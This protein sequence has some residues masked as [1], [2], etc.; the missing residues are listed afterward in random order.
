MPRYGGKNVYIDDSVFQRK[1]K[2]LA[3]QFGVDQKEFIKDQTGLLAREAARFTPPWAGFP[4]FTGNSVGT[5]KDIKAGE[6]A[7]YND[8][9]KICAVISDDAAERARKYSK[10]G[11]IY[12]KGRIVSPGVLASMSSISQHH[13]SNKRG[14]G[15]TRDLP[16]NQVPWVG[17]SIFNAYVKTQQNKAGIAKASF[18][19]ASLALG[20]KGPAVKGIKRHV[21]I[22]DGT[23]KVM[24]SRK[25]PYGL[26]S[27]KADGLFHTMRFLPQLKTN[28]LKKAVKRLEYIGRQSAKKSGFKTN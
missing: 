10:G 27:A 3:K 5:A 14:R 7:I 12:R 26:I 28:R 22:A 25:G 2:K 19:K 24:S 11:P 13:K 17:E 6:W 23:G 4:K 21:I 15:R 8:I 18:Y 20:A 9:K 1:A 16:S